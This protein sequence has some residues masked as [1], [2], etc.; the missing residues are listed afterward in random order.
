M[1]TKRRG[2]IW[3]GVGFWGDSPTFEQQLQLALA[4]FFAEGFECSE[5][6]SGRLSC[7]FCQFSVAEALAPRFVAAIEATTRQALPGASAINLAN[8]HGA[9]LAALRSKAEEWKRGAK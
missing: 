9:A 7:E 1:S 6:H 2:G 3:G 4:A 5:G 8:G